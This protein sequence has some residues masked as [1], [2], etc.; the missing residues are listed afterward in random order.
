MYSIFY[1]YL[2]FWSDFY[3][4]VCLRFYVVIC[5][6]CGFDLWKWWYFFTVWW[7][8]FTVCFH[9]HIHTHKINFSVWKKRLQAMWIVER[10][11]LQVLYWNKMCVFGDGTLLDG[12]C[13]PPTKTHRSQY[14]CG[15][16][17]LSKPDD[18]CFFFA[19]WKKSE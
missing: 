1:L 7:Y 10:M 9:T 12:K 19:Y 16:F 8:H 14:K 2:I 15:I 13:M 3:V 17:I 18:D 4:I 6:C 5:C 11:R